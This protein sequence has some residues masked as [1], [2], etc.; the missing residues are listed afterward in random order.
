MKNLYFLILGRIFIL[1]LSRKQIVTKC[2]FKIL[3]SL[4]S[5]SGFEHHL[6]PFC[7][8]TVH[9]T[10][11]CVAVLV[12]G[13]NSAIVHSFKISEEVHWDPKPIIRGLHPFSLVWSTN[14]FSV[15]SHLLLVT[16]MFQCLL[17]M[18]CGYCSAE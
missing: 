1:T 5:K 10:T 7:K 8:I 3:L 18:D 15:V 4:V 2:P 17:R 16:E 14:L 9:R 13:H 6:G 12:C 11:T